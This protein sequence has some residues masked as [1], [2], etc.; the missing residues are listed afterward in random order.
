[1]TRSFGGDESVL[2]SEALCSR[3]LSNCP[4]VLNTCSAREKGSPVF[5]PFFFGGV[6]L[7]PPNSRLVVQKLFKHYT[8]FRILENS[9][10]L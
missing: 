6:A 2:Y 9:K 5:F 4:E 10:G 3:K 7:E 8:L 1:M